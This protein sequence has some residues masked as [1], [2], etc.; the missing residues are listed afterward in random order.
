MTRLLVTGGAGFIGSNFV[1]YMLERHA[2]YEILALDKL[3]YAGNLKNLEP[4]LGNPRLRFVRHDICDPAVAEAVAGCEVA[5]HF[6]AESHV[7]R[8]IENAADF[9]RTNVEGTWRLVEACRR[10][11]VL[12]FLHVST[13]EVYGSLGPSGKFAETSPLDPSSPYAATKAASDLLVLAAVRTHR[14]PAIV[15]RCSNNYGPFQFP[16]KFIPLMIAQALAGQPLPVYG[17]GRNVRDWIHVADHCRALD[18]ILQGGRVGETYNIGG[19]SERRNLDIA[20]AIL[21]TLG[22]PESLI[23]FVADRPGHDR[24]YA[25]DFTKL[26]ES[27][28]WQPEQDFETGLAKTIRWYQENSPWLEET[29]SGAYRGYFERHYTRRQE[30]FSALPG[31]TRRSSTSF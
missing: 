4:A 28:G 2:D 20:R 11:D 22:Q 15:T 7:D 25:M 3:T 5:V 24:R 26:R 21:K 17:D 14:F 6:A 9:V 30:T 27:L 8:S 1:H 29:R 23:Q 18:L 10:A 19:D 16:E 31:G 13:D 12:R